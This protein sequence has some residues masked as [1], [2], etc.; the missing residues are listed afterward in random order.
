[1]PRYL[2]LWSLLERERF[3][4]PIGRTQVEFGVGDASCFTRHSLDIRMFTV[5][6][7]IVIRDHRDEQKTVCE[8]AE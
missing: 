5:R 2:S 3:S 1:V 8:S 7:L 4:P 6:R